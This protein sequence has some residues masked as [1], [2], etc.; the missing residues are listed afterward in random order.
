MLHIRSRVKQ[1]EE[2]NNEVDLTRP[3]LHIMGCHKLQCTEVAIHHTGVYIYIPWLHT[4]L[5]Q[6]CTMVQ[7]YDGPTDRKVKER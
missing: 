7:S 5:A 6:L 3:T 2:R 4:L 1:I